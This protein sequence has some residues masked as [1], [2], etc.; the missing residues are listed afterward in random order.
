MYE[1]LRS[2]EGYIWVVDFVSLCLIIRLSYTAKTISSVLI[3]LGIGVFIGGVSFQYGALIVQPNPA[4][5]KT[6]LQQWLTDNM[7]IKLAVW[8]L[9][10][11]ALD[12]L[13]LIFI[14]KLH[15]AAK[16]S[17]DYITKMIA[18][19]F[20]VHGTIN[21]ARYLERLTTDGNYLKEVYSFG[22]PS[23]NIGTSVVC[24]SFAVVTLIKHYRLQQN[25]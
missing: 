5:D 17:G 8:Y 19:A 9:G 14:G 22:I 3:S 10:F 16:I 2:I 13:A 25:N 23:I 4:I 11:V 15:R 12:C 1:Y 21:I 6:A 24:L 20:Y 7:Q 18:F